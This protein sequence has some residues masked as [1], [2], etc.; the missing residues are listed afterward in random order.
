MGVVST[1]MSVGIGGDIYRHIAVGNSQR[2][3]FGCSRVQHCRTAG[4]CAFKE[5]ER[6]RGRERALTC[7]YRWPLGRHQERKRNT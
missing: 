1:V 7:C 4:V 3:L 5:G 2:L 6:E